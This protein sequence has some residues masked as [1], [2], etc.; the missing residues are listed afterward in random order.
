MGAEMQSVTD[1]RPGLP[2][3]TDRVRHFAAADEEAVRRICFDTALAGRPMR[4]VFDDETWVSEALVGYYI[5]FER[6]H[7]HVA[8]VNGCVSGYLS[9]CADTIRYERQFA[10]RIVPRLI[11]RFGVRGH[12]VQASGRAMVAAAVRHARAWW[13]VKHAVVRD[14]PAHLHVNLAAAARGRGLGTRLVGEFLAQMRA[15]GV[16]GVHVATQSDAARRFFL[17]SGFEEFA[18]VRLPVAL[19]VGTGTGWL[20]VRRIGGTGK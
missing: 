16:P 7:L 13:R 20:L 18:T 10:R 4:D 19:G 3:G 12:I 2:T 1:V 11:L 8:E 17:R 6:T 9:G 15:A 5:R 14:W